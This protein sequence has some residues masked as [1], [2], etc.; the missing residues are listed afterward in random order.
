[1]TKD[2]RIIFAAKLMAGSIIGASKHEIPISE[3]FFAGSENA[4]RGY[5][6]ES[7]CPIGCHHKL[8]GGRSLLIQSIELR[9]RIGKN[10]GMV[11]FYEIGN[12]FPSYIPDFRQEFLQSAGAGIR[13]YTPVGPLRLDIAFPLNRRRHFDQPFEIYFSIGQS[14]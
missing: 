1:L 3:R 11:G 2:K 8:L 5:A 7:V 10:F 6:F 12:V 4:L 9:T 14:F 13:Y